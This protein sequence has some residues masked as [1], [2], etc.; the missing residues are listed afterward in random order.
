MYGG[1][2]CLILSLA[3]I[4]SEGLYDQKRKNIGVTRAEIISLYRM[5]HLDFIFQNESR[6]WDGTPRVLGECRQ[7]PKDHLTS[8]WVGPENGYLEQASITFALSGR[9]SNAFRLKGALALN[10][11]LAAVFRKEEMKNPTM[12][13]WLESAL[14]LD[15]NTTMYRDELR[16]KL[17]VIKPRDGRLY[18][19]TVDTG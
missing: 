13:D 7:C 5:P 15:E 19:L 6:L 16:I 10:S 9:I 17:T 12:G 4:E 1:V 11:L 2:L 3:I 18:V 14:L 8:D